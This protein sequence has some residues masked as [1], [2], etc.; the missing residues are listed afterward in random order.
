VAR[1]RGT[2]INISSITGVA[3]EVLNGVYGGA[4]AFVL[5]LSLSLHKELAEKNVRY[6]SGPAWGNGHGLLGHSRRAS[7]ASPERNC[8]EG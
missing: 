7:C 5:A 4:K 6:P 3:L 1:G 8:D 2:I